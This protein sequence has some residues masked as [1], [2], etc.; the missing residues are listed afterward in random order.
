MASRRVRVVWSERARDALDEAVA[1]VAEDAPDTAR[2]LLRTVLDAAA[3]LDLFSSRGRIVPELNDI[4]FRE[5]FVDPFRLIYQVTPSEV[6][7]V[8]LLHQARDFPT[9]QR[10]QQWDE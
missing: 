4:A 5:L 7:I 9:W 6:T 3:S 1:Y 8:A 2:R 10:E